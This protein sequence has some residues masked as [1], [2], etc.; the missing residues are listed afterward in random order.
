MDTVVFFSWLFLWHGRLARAVRGA[1]RSS[2]HRSAG[3]AWARRPCHVHQPGFVIPRSPVTRRTRLHEILVAN[4]ELLHQ[5]GGE[6]HARLALRRLPAEVRDL[7]ERSK[8]RA[9]IAVAVEAPA[10]A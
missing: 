10:H 5:V 4:A 9:R 2:I 8:V 3:A 1:S 6:L 7:V